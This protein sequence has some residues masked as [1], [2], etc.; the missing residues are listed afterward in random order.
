MNMKEKYNKEVVPALQKKFAYKNIMEVPKIDKVVIN[1]GFGKLIT[2]KTG[3]DYRKTLDGIVG[4]LSNIAGQ[5]AT[6]TKAKHSIAGFKVR[7]GSPIGAKVTLRGSKMYDFLDRLANIVLPRSRDFRGIGLSTVD[8]YGNLS[9]GIKEHI[10][11]PEISP[12]NVKDMFGLQVTV[13]TTASNKEEGLELFR[14]LG[15]PFKI[16]EK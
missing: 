7:Q 14:L 4:D 12:E 10:F 6:L 13:A 3:D 8:S 5:H 11:F 2:P 15:F 1:T 16:E 9:L